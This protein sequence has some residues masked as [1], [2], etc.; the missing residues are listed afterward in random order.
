[1]S[2]QIWAPG[3]EAFSLVQCLSQAQLSFQVLAD[4]VDVQSN[5]PLLLVYADPLAWIA[6][7][8]PAVPAAAASALLASLPAHVASGAAC[9]LVNLSCTPLPTLVAWCVE[10]TTPPP[11]ESSAHF[12]AAD[13]FD[14][15]LAMTWLQT[16][17]QTLQAYQALEAH[18]LAAALDRREPDQ[19]CLERYRKAAH[20][21]AL[22]AGRAERVS[23]EADLRELAAQLEPMQDQQ[24]EALALREQLA[25]L[26]Y[27]LQEAENLQARCSELQLSLQAQQQDLE[28]LARRQA[29]LE[30]LVRDGSAASLRMENRLAQAL[31]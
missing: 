16:H 17:P 11:L 30:C 6:N 5:Q 22:L 10:P 1:M 15:L 9:R 3:V 28:Q 25:R 18:P 24:L 14:A 23:I 27:R 2:I 7:K 31:A 8:E 20:L 4:S 13:P 12:A 19:A 29:L 21:D 26:Q